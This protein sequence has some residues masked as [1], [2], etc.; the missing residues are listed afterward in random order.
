[1]TYS[2][3][4]NRSID[5]KG[6]SESST[7]SARCVHTCYACDGQTMN[8]TTGKNSKKIQIFHKHEIKNP[9]NNDFSVVKNENY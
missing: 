1:M 2:L 6:S 5:F 9:K 4:K 3:F 8:K 7:T